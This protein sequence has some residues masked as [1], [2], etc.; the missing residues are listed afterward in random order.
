MTVL[1]KHRLRAIVYYYIKPGPADLE[2]AAPRLKK[3][4]VGAGIFPGEVATA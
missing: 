4:D 1:I 3:Y 2:R